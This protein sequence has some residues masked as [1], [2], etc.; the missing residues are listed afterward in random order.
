MADF[1]RG[2]KAGVV[3]G[4]VYMAVA[5]ILGAI[6][7]NNPL[8]VPYF[9]YGT[10]IT[11]LF[12]L[13]ALTDPLSVISFLFQYIVRGIVFGAVFAALYDFL[14]GVKSIGKGVMLSVFVWILSAVWLIYITPG[15]PTDGSSIL[16]YCGGGAVD[17]SAIWPA[18]AGIT[19]A[20]IFGAVTGFLWDRFQ[21]KRVA[22]A[23]KGSS[24]LLLSFI[25]GGITW[26]YFAALFLLAVVINREVPAI[27]PEFWWSELLA[28]LAVFLGLPGWILADVAWRKTR[29][30][31]SGFK[32]GVAGGVLMALTGFMLLPGVL[33]IIG[34]MFSGRKAAA[35]PSPAEAIVR[36][37]IARTGEQKKR[38]N[39]N[40]NII[41]L[42]TSMTVL[43]ITIIVGY[44]TSPTP[45][46][47]EIWT[48][49]DLNAT[50][51]NLG[52]SYLLMNDLDSAIPGYEELASETANQGQGWQPIGTFIPQQADHGILG[53]EGTFDGQ[54]Y[55]IHD[56]FINRPDEDAVGLFRHVGREGVIKNIG[57]V[58]ATVTGDDFVGTL[59][60]WN[61]GAV[62]NS[63]FTSNMTGDYFVGGLAGLNDGT[64][65]NSDSTGSVTGN[66]NVGG[67][68][69]QN[70]GAVSN[71]Y[72]TNSVSGNYDVGG[73]VG[74]NFDTVSNS[75]S[76][77]NVT[78]NSSVGGLMGANSGTV[79]NSY[80]TGSV[81]GNSSVG[82]LVG[83][84]FD[85]TVSNCYSTGSVTGNSS[86]GGLVGDTFD[87]TVSD[88]YSTGSVTGNSSVGGLVGKNMRS[89]VS[90]S[91]WDTETSG[92]S[93][94]AG[95]TGKTTAEMKNIA[96]FAGSAWNI[97]MVAPG[98][99][100]STYIWNIVD[101]V[102]YPFLS[103]HSGCPQGHISPT[104][105]EIET[106][107]SGY[108][109]LTVSPAR[110]CANVGEQIEIRCTIYCLINTIVN[111][112][113]V[114]VFLFDS[115][116][117]VTRERAMTKDSYWSAHTVYTIIGDEAYYQLKVNFTFPRGEPGEHS[118]YGAYSFPIVVSQNK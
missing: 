18:L 77:A 93:A 110:V 42:I 91:F 52:G 83:D 113:S 15:W 54:G 75:Y 80:F 43:T 111:I 37:K 79:R 20:L 98:E 112:S 34:G 32:W 82:G 19:T 71:S 59:V 13:A 67:L 44:T 64:V 45:T 107:P 50:R 6:Y 29:M 65:S 40:R 66:Y 55:E 68:V 61:H 2:I 49:Y 51:D 62:C 12:S 101:N 92:Q 102:T 104:R 35:E 69:G 108:F 1:G 47:N 46:P 97:A 63:Y 22:E 117:S 9:L 10:G 3:T 72:A 5:A 24:A 4:L 114:E 116:D 88:S 11:P 26:A 27:Q 85:G 100:N 16:T 105:M 56:L 14:P 30:D 96:A 106:I 25:L 89:T 17:L 36:D 48:W 95:G 87:G 41:L 8:S 60:G 57:V 7:H 84:T 76:S 115:Y 33:A 28:I 70:L 74:W 21:G 73:L 81:T 94:S 78:G 58:N 90:N 39:I 109:Q 118:E 38:T 31:K 99:T 53:F 86:V 23:K 103:W